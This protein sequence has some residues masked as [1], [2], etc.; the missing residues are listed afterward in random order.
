MIFRGGHQYTGGATVNLLI[1]LGIFV[2][3]ALRLDAILDFIWR[4]W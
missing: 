1:V 2:A 3:V 4:T